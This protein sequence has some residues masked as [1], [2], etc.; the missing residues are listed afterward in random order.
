LAVGFVDKKLAQ[1]F[2]SSFAK[3]CSAELQRIAARE[4]AEITAG[5]LPAIGCSSER[6]TSRPSVESSY[7]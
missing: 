3:D 2:W 6:L 1:K 7:P 4:S 5:K